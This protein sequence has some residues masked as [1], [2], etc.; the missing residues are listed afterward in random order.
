MTR[1]MRRKRVTCVAAAACL[2]LQLGHLL[3]LVV[4]ERVHGGN[5]VLHERQ[6]VLDVL[7]QHRLH[8]E[9]V[10]VLRSRGARKHPGRG[11]RVWT[12]A[13]VLR[14]CAC[15][16]GAGVEE[17]AAGVLRHDVD[18]V[19]HVDVEVVQQPL[20]VRALVAHLAPARSL[21]LQRARARLRRGA[22]ARVSARRRTVPRGCREVVSIR[23]ARARG[24]PQGGR[25]LAA[26]NC[27]L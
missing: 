14:V 6:R 10:P 15:L 18:G 20:Q 8:E 1:K 24:R 5:F 16:V 7:Q 27:L 13:R 9:L 26:Q 4:D 11:E 3:A 17:L 12:R 23:R 2:E 22:S 19:V 25:A 21:E